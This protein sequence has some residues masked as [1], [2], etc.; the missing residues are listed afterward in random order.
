MIIK[1]TWNAHFIMICIISCEGKNIF[2]KL[3]VSSNKYLYP[4]NIMDVIAC[5]IHIHKYKVDG[6][7]IWG[8]SLRMR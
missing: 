7:W 3:F 8:T 1:H 4:C 6:R 2:T 5:V